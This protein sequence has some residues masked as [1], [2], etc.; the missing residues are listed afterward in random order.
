MKKRILAVV[1]AMMMTSAMAV[2]CGADEGA[3]APET[4]AAAPVEGTEMQEEDE[5]PAEAQEPQAD[6]ENAE[7]EGTEEQAPETE[8]E[9]NGEA[10]GET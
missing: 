4:E 6:E 10:E 2:A 8:A 7:T 3:A 1:L 9:E 5:T